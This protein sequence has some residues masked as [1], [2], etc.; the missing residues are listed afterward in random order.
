M[1]TQSLILGTDEAAFLDERRKGIGGSDIHHVMNEPPYGCAY[2]LARQKRGDDPDYTTTKRMERLFKRGHRLEEV[3][4][5]E[6]EAETGHRVRRM[7][8]RLDKERSWR[9]V[10]CDRQILTF[11][12]RGP[13]AL[14][15]KTANDWVFGGFKVNG[16]PPAYLL[17]LQWAMAVTGYK[18]GAFAVLN[19]SSF[20]L[21]TFE[22][23]RNER[24]IGIIEQ[25]VDKFWSDV[26]QGILPEPGEQLDGCLYRHPGKEEPKHPR[27]ET[28]I[29]SL[30]AE[31]DSEQFVERCRDYLDAK[32]EADRADELLT[33]AQSALH[34]MLGER[35]RVV[36]PSLR[37]KISYIQQ[38]NSMVWDTKYLDC[39]CPEELA[40]KAKKTKRGARA[41][42]VT[43]GKEQTK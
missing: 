28:E 4:A 25:A 2:C 35:Q 41:L 8:Q 9:M 19:P 7:P 11:D 34:D 10:H 1:S 3:V 12:E 14:E 23:E 29:A 5:E 6:Y 13:G 36:V 24:L 38:A 16:L 31:D 30:D 42:R 17:Q 43:I 26:Q 33:M 40:A 37:A 27:S 20:E 39:H 22:Q 18:W 21:L 15:C 32:K